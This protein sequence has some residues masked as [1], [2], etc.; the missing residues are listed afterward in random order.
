MSSWLAP[1]L[2]L[3]LREEGAWGYE[4]ARR[5]EVS[6][7]GETRSEALYWVLGQMEREGMVLSERDGSGKGLPRRWCSITASGEAYLKTWAGSLAR[8]GE[9]VD[10]PLAFTRGSRARPEAR[11]E[12]K[13]QVSYEIGRG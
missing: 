2:L 10:L 6:G 9:V 11:R 1:L 7:F 8:Y 5:T 3:F 12:V 13:T 4:L